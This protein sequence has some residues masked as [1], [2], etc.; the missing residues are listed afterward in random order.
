M[1]EIVPV[2]ENHESI[3][4]GQCTV[5]LDRQENVVGDMGC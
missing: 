5:R 3:R 1:R 4:L 2:G